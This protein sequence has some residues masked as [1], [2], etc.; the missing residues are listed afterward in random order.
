[1]TFITL[2]LAKVQQRV[3][4]TDEDA[5]LA[6]LISAA[7][8]TAIGYLN[9]QVYETQEALDAAVLD[10]KA[11]D[12]PMVINDAV[13]AAMLLIFGHLYANRE[14]VVIGAH[15][16]ELPNGSTALLDLFREHTGA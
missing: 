8:L 11:G 5:L 13:R 7:E 6:V 16:T 12:C 10:G 4:G 15:V 3:D 2:D 9:R 14:D 1:M